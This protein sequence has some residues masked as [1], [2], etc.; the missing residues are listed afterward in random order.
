MLPSI[1]GAI[2]LPE[3]LKKTNNLGKRNGNWKL[4][5]VF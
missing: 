2:P 1:K 4:L 5:P 3:V